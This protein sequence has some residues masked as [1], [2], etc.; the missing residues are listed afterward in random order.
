MIPQSIQGLQ[1]D[2]PR[3]YEAMLEIYRNIEK[4]NAELFPTISQAINDILDTPIAAPINFTVSTTTTSVVFS[5]DGVLNAGGYEIRVGSTWDTST[6]VLRTISTQAIILPVVIGNYNYLIKSINRAGSYSPDVS[7][8]QLTITGPG[9]ITISGTVIDNNILLNW[10]EPE[11]EFGLLH[12]HIYRNGI[13]IGQVSS[14]FFTYFETASGTYTYGI[15]AHDLANNHSDIISNIVLSVSQPPDF[16]LE[17]TLTA[18]LSNPSAESNTAL[19]ETAEG[20]KLI[21]CVNN[22]ETW[23]D[24]FVN[25]SWNTIQDQIDAGYPLYAEPA[26]TSGYFEYIF[27]FGA[28]F[29]N[30]I[31]GAQWLEEALD[32][33]I[34]VTVE[35]SYSTDNITYTT[36]ESGPNLFATTMRYAKVRLIFAPDDD[37]SLSFIY[38]FV[39]FINVK[40]EMDGG[41]AEVFA[42]DVGGTVV[43]FN[44]AFKDV[45]S[46]TATPLAL[47]EQNAIVDFTDIPNPTDFAILL[48][49]D[50][51]VRIDGTVYW[52]ARGIL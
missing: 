35:I 50:T 4:I 15:Q 27:D 23:D 21:V 12:Y 9:Q 17:D 49:D 5:W 7:S 44:K 41:S 31:I 33:D 32:G 24:H 19:V 13:E 34:N 16:V 6:F 10:E 40:R 8:A 45:E 20:Q 38:D 47:V 3:L 36:P 22:T 43:N 42:A 48:F 18:D 1:K 14:T 29:N 52:K 26:E 2:S 30:V 39:C 25:N 46:I 28:T 51:G 11:S 37:V